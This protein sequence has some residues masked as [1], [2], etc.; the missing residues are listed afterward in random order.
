MEGEILTTSKDRI[1]RIS[2]RNQSSKVHPQ[3][4][5]DRKN[6]DVRRTCPKDRALR[7]TSLVISKDMLNNTGEHMRLL[8][9]GTSC[10]VKAE[11]GAEDRTQVVRQQRNP[12]ERT[13]QFQHVER[14][15]H[16]ASY[17]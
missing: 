8:G 11:W 15:L 6:Y 10:K 9:K 2:V 16:T 4:L 13:E 14:F 5:V 3:L 12:L 1:A 17:F 7:V